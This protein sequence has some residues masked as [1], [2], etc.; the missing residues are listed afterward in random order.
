MLKNRASFLLFLLLFLG[1][2][3]LGA[4]ES[5]KAIVLKN[6]PPQYMTDK[7]GKPT[8]FAIEMIE[9]VAKRAGY[10]IEYIVVDSWPQSNELFYK[11]KIG[12][13]IPNSGITQE[14]QKDAIFTVP[15]ETFDIG[16]FKR[17]TSAHLKKYADIKDS[18][19]VTL[20]DNLGHT[21]MKTKR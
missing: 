21:I 6:F 5:I 18:L 15:M 20:D 17:S 14:R 7:D 12:D 16:M 11:Q 8:G 1:F 9:E 4:Q 13:I 19:V 2:E 3:R 10:D